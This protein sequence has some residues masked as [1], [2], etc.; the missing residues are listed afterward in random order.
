MNKNNNKLLVITGPTGMG[1]TKLAVKLASQFSGEIVSADSRQVYKGMDIGTGKD[2]KDFRLKISDFR[3]KNI[4]HHLIDVVSPK[5]AFNLAKFVKL[6]N[7]T[8]KDIQTRGKLPILTGGTGLYVQA[9]VDGY[10]LSGVKPDKELRKKLEN[11]SVEKLQKKLK[12]LDPD[13]DV[14]FNKRYLIRYIE[15]AT[16]T[17]T[18]LKKLL[19]KKG[20]DY[21]CL[22]MAIT[23]P[24]DIIN[25]RIDKRLIERIEREGMIKEIKDLHFKNKVSWK[26]LE[27]FGLEYKFVSQYLQGKLEENEMIEKLAIAIHQFAKRQMNWLHRWERQ[28]RKIY[29]IK[30][31][32][33]GKKITGKWIK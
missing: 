19:V 6:A 17:K 2:L 27:S 14:V 22:V 30:N 10:S 8:I 1:K 33:E 31:Y 4:K 23:F 11:M 7:K 15:I 25:K 24:R 20:S 32:N 13:F 26:R 28:G 18:K 3:F 9:I 12:K 21:D 5:T 29:W 16:K